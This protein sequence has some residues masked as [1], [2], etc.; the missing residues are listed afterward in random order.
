MWFTLS[1]T[2]SVVAY[3]LLS[4]ALRMSVGATSV[5]YLMAHG[6]S[7][8]EVGF[9]KSMQAMIILALDV[10]LG[11]LADRWGR[12]AVLALAGFSTALW[13]ALT[14]TAASV[15][16]FF[17]AE[18]FNALSLALF[19]GAFSALMLDAYNKEK[20]QNDYENILGWYGKWQFA[21]MGVA[22]F[23]GATLGGTT[24]PALWWAAATGT[25]LLSI[26]TPFMLPKDPP[27]KAAA[28]A[29]V[30][31]RHDLRAMTAVLTKHRGI[32]FMTSAYVALTLGLQVLLQLWQPLLVGGDPADAPGWMLGSTFVLLLVAQSIA[33]EHARKSPRAG[34]PQV[35][36][37]TIAIGF[38]LLYYGA[39]NTPVL[40][41][42]TVVVL[43][44]YVMRRVCVWLM[45]EIHRVLPRDLWATTE[46]ALSTLMRVIFMALMPLIGVA[47]RQAS[48]AAIALTLGGLLVLT[49]VLLI[50]ITRAP[51]VESGDIP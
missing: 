12:R 11:Y 9:M 10:P 31:M 30:G 7:L 37:G 27:R 17:V 36:C 40:A 50:A 43:A 47:G 42:L 1:P 34:L 51:D 26:A 16:V 25:A 21:L 15:P 49:T 35:F 23:F 6:V 19:N 13:L 29:P 44:F 2:Q 3:G 20:G 4:N 5:V 33:S 39:P 48:L 28:D 46:S 24:S 38:L 32:L 22:A 8:T 41:V 14:A 45:A 18:A